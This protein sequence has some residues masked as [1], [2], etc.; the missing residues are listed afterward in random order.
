ML[1]PGTR[2]ARFSSLVVFPCFHHSGDA[3]LLSPLMAAV[4][5]SPDGLGKQVFN[6]GRRR[7]VSAEAKQTAARI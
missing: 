4:L 1:G 6:Q 2:T 5:A 7:I 3:P